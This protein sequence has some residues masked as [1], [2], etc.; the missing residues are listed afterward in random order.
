MNVQSL[1]LRGSER[2][3]SEQP[4]CKEQGLWGSHI[5][6]GKSSSWTRKYGNWQFAALPLLYLRKLGNVSDRGCPKNIKEANLFAKG[7]NN[8]G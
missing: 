8:T 2:E 4:P 3:V 1:I 7:G 6:G 5:Q